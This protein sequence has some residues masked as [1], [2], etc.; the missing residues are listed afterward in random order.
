MKKILMGVAAL[1]A[2][3]A[4]MAQSDGYYDKKHEVGITYGIDSNSQ[5]IDAFEAVGG[6]VV[7]VTLDGDSW[8]GPISVEYFYH[9]KNWLGVGG[10]L[11][12][13]QM[14]QDVYLNG[15]KNGKDGESTNDYLTLMPAVKAD[16]LRKSHFGMYSKLALGFTYRSEK[17]KYNTAGH[18]NF[19]DS[20]FHVN[21]QMTL[22]GLEAGGQSLRGFVELGFGEQG[23]LLLGARYKF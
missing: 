21:W 17:I 13:G 1:M 18:N 7:G 14:K 11:A 3:T 10:I 16:W 5:I 2:T 8:I 15:K 20:E 23:I 22:L 4:V 6:A 9:P 19:D 12:Y